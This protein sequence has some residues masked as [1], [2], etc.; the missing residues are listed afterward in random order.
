M[1]LFVFSTIP[2]KTEE[3]ER[4]IGFDY[5]KTLLEP[6][7][8]FGRK[9]FKHLK[10]LSFEHIVQHLNDIT[11]F[12]RLINQSVITQ[13]II[14]EFEN[15]I[16]ISKSVERLKSGEVLDEVEL[17]EL[18][19]YALVVENIREK[20]SGKVP[21]DLLPPQLVNVIDILDPE[22]TRLPTFYV[23]DIYSEELEEIRKKKRELI[24]LKTYDESQLAEL[25]EQEIR[26]EKQILKDISAKLYDYSNI[27]T[28]SIEKV[29]Y[30]D[31][32]ITKA[33]LAINCELSK[34]EIVNFEKDFKDFNIHIENMFNPKLKEELKSKS[35]NYQPVSIDIR[36]GVTII[37]GANMSGKSVILRTVALVQ[38]MAQ[39][40]FF[41]PAQRCKTIFLD[42]IAIIAE[43]YQ[44]PLSGLSSFGSEILMI[45]EALSR[46]K[47]S[48][49]LVLIDEPART[50][51]PYEAN[52]IVNAI[53]DEFES[54]G[55]YTL[56]V[57]H[58][59]DIR[60]KKRLRVKGLREDIGFS[61]SEQPEKLIENIQ[62]YIDYT[63]IESNE[64]TVPKEAIKI[65]ELLG[66]NQQIIKK[67]RENLNNSKLG[68]Y[69]D[70]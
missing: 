43:D 22:K 31:V 37:V 28:E 56:I 23:Y 50:T 46:A 15:V 13:E 47:L 33:K 49:S 59:D 61:F 41:V 38:Y 62:N 36:P 55:S 6:K 27:I 64:S 42:S 9:Y 65:M 7:T 12:V 8:P 11:L 39:L 69:K 19:N 68:R 70:V 54:T 66:I 48:R 32:I 63:L 30:L 17:F 4:I 52:A 14:K 18:K 35:K 26:L 45:N 25:S 53:V 21:E 51:N 40:G 67:A 10:P 29:K 58:L 16:D 60:S 24:K 1:K 57:T 34:P 44:K 2:S 5:V 3:F 20:I